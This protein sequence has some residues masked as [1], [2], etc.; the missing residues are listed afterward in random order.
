MTT[1]TFTAL[2]LLPVL[3]AAACGGAEQEPAAAPG[4]AITA[5][6]VMAESL[7]ALLPVDGT[8]QGAERA[9]LSTRM[10]ARIVAIDADVGARVQRGQA[11]IR[12]GVDDVAANR[13]Q[14]EAGVAAAEAAHAEAVRQAARMDTLL[15]QDAVARVQRDQAHLQRD[16]AAAQLAAANAALAQVDA[17]S[18]Y[19][20]IRAPF[21][22]AV[23][24]RLVNVGDLAV[25][26]TPL[27]VVEGAGPREAVLA[28]PAD[29]ARELR[30]GATVQVAGP[31]GWRGP[32][33]LRAVGA[34]A[35][36]MTRT[37]EVRATLPSDWPT[38]VAVTA[39]VPHGVR[40]TIAIPERAVVR[41]GQLTGV[42][43]VTPEGSVLRWVRLGRS[44]TAA[45]QAA[46]PRVEVLSG[47]RAGERVAL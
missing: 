15:A 37:V 25:P 5:F 28:V 40:E 24:Q 30:P 18:A 1:R 47:L 45:E 10:M 31:T 11:L 16:Q 41:R 19:A 13:A 14:A 46:D 44:L 36:P 29:V 39:L 33:T 6:T 22:G 23:S 32:A 4:A 43:V 2:A 20:T 17:A 38:G 21:A 8:V 9:V 7:P 12:L 26:G 42:R 3:T 34:G 35:D 27:I